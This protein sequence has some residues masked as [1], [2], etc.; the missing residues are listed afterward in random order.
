MF[1]RL[2]CRLTDHRM[3]WHP[4]A[5]PWCLRCKADDYWPARATLGGW[6]E[7]KLFDLRARWKERFGFRRCEHCGARWGRHGEDCIPF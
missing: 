5:P 6:W 3:D 7:R 1:R 4:Q 2:V